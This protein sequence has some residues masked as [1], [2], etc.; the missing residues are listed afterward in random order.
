M[1]AHRNF[2]L[3]V[4]LAAA[5]A[6]PALG[7]VA[8]P[9]AAPAKSGQHA[10]VPDFSGIW[11]HGNLPWFIPCGVG[12]RPG[13]QPV[14]GKGE[15]R[16]RLQLAGRRL[17]EPDPAALGRRGRE[18]EGRALARKRTFP[19]PSGTCWPE[20]V[21]Y[22]FKHAAMEMLQLPDQVVMLFNENHEVR[23]VRMNQPHPAEVT[24]SWHGDA[25]GRY[26]GDTL[27]V[28]TV[29]IKTDR[30]Y[31]M[32]DLFGTPFTEKLH[33]VERYRLI[34]YEDAKDAMQ[35]GTK[36]NRRVG[37]PYD[38]GYKDKYL[39]GPLRHRGP[40]RL[41]DALDRRHDL[42][43]RARRIPRT[44]LR[45]EHVFVPQQSGCGFPAR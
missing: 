38:P 5:A 32:I 12:P 43:A 16:Q 8:T 45:R 26:E 28:D 33:V 3:L 25:V 20:P 6:T 7:Q 39:A 35:R 42:F 19:R 36:E 1:T 15:R 37:G 23:H 2:L 4:T 24:P 21:P 14:A 31:A 44:G 40:R 13:D 10:A 22:L 11:R 34:D 30:P 27:V 41:H 18:E 29:G 9:A 17:Q